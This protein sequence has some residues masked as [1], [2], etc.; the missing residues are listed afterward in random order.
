MTVE[1]REINPDYIVS[2]DGQVGSRRR[3]KLK[4]LK[5]R[6]H[7]GYLDLLIWTGSGPKRRRTV[8]QLVAEQFLGPK[9]TPRHQVNHKNGNRAD[10]R[11]CN[12]EW[13]TPSQ[14]K[15]HSYDV[16]GKKSPRGEASGQ[17]RLTEDNVREIRTR[18]AAGETISSISVV[19]GIGGSQISR[20][21]RRK[22]WEHVL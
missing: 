3:G 7:N 21:T 4:I 1:W 16:L 20:I 9:P 12:L 6:R 2:S 15:Q 11:D 17:A 19:Y 14:N 5:P 18:R 8:H 22:A 10:N 13:V